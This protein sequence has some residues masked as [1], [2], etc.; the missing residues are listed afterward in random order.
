MEYK[1]ETA[2]NNYEDF[3]SGRVLYNAR[4]TTSFPVRL[5]SEIVQRCFDILEKK[6]NAGPY[7]LH[8]PCCGGAYLLTVSGL[9]HGHRLQRLIASDADPGVL[10]IAA[11]NLALLTP[12]GLS[13]RK[14]QLKAL[15][16]LHGKPSHEEALKSVDRIEGLILRSRIA[17]I[18]TFQGDVTAPDESRKRPSGVQILLTD[19]PYGNIA[20]WSGDRTDP[21]GALFRYAYGLLDSAQSVMAVVADKAQLL[22]HERFRRLQYWKVGKRQIGIFEPIRETDEI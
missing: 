7:T 21:L 17:K 22:K 20:S 13:K 1:F 11:R 10:G 5:A 18:E 3:A 4:G 14:A 6:G 12:E 9:L 2:R 15:A 8:D 19:V 16:E